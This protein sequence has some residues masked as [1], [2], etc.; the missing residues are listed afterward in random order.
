M[1]RYFPLFAVKVESGMELNGMERHFAD[2]CPP[3]Q[4]NFALYIL[5]SYCPKESPIKNILKGFLVSIPQRGV[6]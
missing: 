5:G 3:P 2:L 4:A 1:E 6:P